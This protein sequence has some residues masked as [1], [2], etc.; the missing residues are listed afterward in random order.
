[1]MKFV[2]GLVLGV[3][4]GGVLSQ[5]LGEKTERETA[6]YAID[7]GERSCCTHLKGIATSG[8]CDRKWMEDYVR[9]MR[10]DEV[11]KRIRRDVER[12]NPPR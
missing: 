9:A 11:D 5:K 4:I 7:V 6:A 1:M 2:G 12:F 10:C 3:V 8:A